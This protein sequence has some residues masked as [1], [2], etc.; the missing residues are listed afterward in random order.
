MNMMRDATSEPTQSKAV[1]FRLLS[2]K[3]GNR[4][5][6]KTALGTRDRMRSQVRKVV[7]SIFEAER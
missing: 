7:G 1:C 6:H 2:P 3:S 4:S 5:S